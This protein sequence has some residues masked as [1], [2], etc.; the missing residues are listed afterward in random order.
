MQNDQQLPWLCWLPLFF[1]TLPVGI[2]AQESCNP[3]AQIV[4]AQGQISLNGNIL[5]N[6]IAMRNRTNIC[7]G[8]LISAGDLSRA[9]ITILNSDAVVRI[10]QNTELRLN[11]EEIS[12]PSF[13]ELLKGAINILS[14]A[15]LKL[16]VKTAFVN[17]AVEG[18]EFHVRVTD[19]QAVVT[20]LEGTVSVTDRAGANEV[21]VH[22]NQ[23]VSARRGQAPRIDASVDESNVGTAVQWAHFYPPVIDYEKPVTGLTKNDPLFHVR[24]AAQYLDTGA[25]DNARQAINAAKRLDNDNEEAWALSL[26]IELAQYDRTPKRTRLIR[27]FLDAAQDRTFATPTALIALSYAQQWDFELQAALKSL[28]TAD[29]LDK[30]NVLVVAR[31]S[32]VWLSLGDLDEAEKQARRANDISASA[33]AKTVLGFTYLAQIKIAEAEAAFNG[34]IGESP[35]DPLPRLGLGLAKIRRGDLDGGRLEIVAAL[36]EGQGSAVLRSYLGKAYY[37]G[38]DEPQDADQYAIAKDLDPNDPTA[39]FYDAIRLQTSNQP[40]AALHELQESIDKNDNRAVYRS[41]LLLDEDLAARSASLGR[42]FTDLGFEQR[43]LIEGWK[44]V[45]AD[46]SEHSGHRF[47]ADTYSILPRH[48][49]ARVSELLQSQLLQ[50]INLTPIQPQLAESNLFILSG[51]GPSAIGFNEFNPLFTGDGYGVQLNGIGGQNST[52]GNDL[53]VSGLNGR[54][55]YSVGQFYYKTDGF[56]ENND[57]ERAVY[58]AFVQFAATHKTS[59]QAEI[60]SARA[61]SGDLSLLFLPDLFSPFR[62]IDE[63]FDMARIGFH[64]SFTPGSEIIASAQFGQRDDKRTDEFGVPG[65]FSG[66]LEILTESD[67]WIFEIQHLFRRKNFKLITGVGH[68]QRDRQDVE[69]LNTEFPFPPF[70]DASVT[71]RDDNA[72]QTNLYAYSLTDLSDE[73]T[74]SLGISADFYNGDFFDR[75]Q[76]NPKFGLTWTP[77]SDTTVRLAAFR[78]M[79]RGLVSDQTVEPTQVA[80]FNQFFDGFEGDGGWRYGFAVDQ[81][82]SQNFYGGIEYSIRELEEVSITRPPAPAPPVVGRFDLEEDFG[83]AYVYWTATNSLALSAEYQYEYFDPEVLGEEALIELT[84]QRFPVSITNSWPNGW[85]AKLR[86]SYVDQ[87]GMFQDGLMAVGGRDSFWIID[88]S[89]GY[90]LKNRRGIISVEAKNLLDEEF[91]FQDTDPKSPQIQPDRLVLVRITLS[92]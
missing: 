15:P 48:E 83:R 69:T 71:I 91:Q 78:M 73:L 6:S 77:S 18:T 57:Q 42:I 26:I 63:E 25:V 34:A 49:I 28:Q 88:T 89:L 13:L 76:V 81:Q 23:A 85:T 1:L 80:G 92:F 7:V 41:R 79:Q 82:F 31:L 33:R 61:E 30:H 38:R 72:V 8:D 4:S 56:R 39:W 40:I 11:V 24:R 54:V 16:G 21:S 29:E 74:L 75:D 43:A 9:A 60:R 55:S 19:D 22:E 27:N 50:P 36:V 32:E 59:V 3:V 20:V 84:T 87:E 65:V 17:A 52:A 70:S 35:S 2:V 37:E 68:F 51:A 67:T 12:D 47:L 44:S 58:N 53:V 46:P 90:R 10:D 45:N 14:P 66:D 64:H 86:G 5:D 62:R